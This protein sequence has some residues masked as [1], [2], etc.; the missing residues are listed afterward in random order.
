MAKLHFPGLDPAAA[1]WLAERRH[2]KAFGLDT[3]SIDYGQSSLFESHQMLAR[4]RIPIFENVAQIAELPATG[5]M[6][7]A[8]PIEDQRG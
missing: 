5:A 4:N 1:Q 2:I 7:V 3:A 8:L 6:V